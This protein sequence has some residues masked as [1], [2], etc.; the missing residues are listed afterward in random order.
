MVIRFP[1]ISST[2]LPVEI[3]LDVKVEMSES[4]LVIC[5]C[6][7]CPVVI[8]FPLMSSTIAPVEMRLAVLLSVEVLSTPVAAFNAVMSP[9]LSV[10]RPDTVVISVVRV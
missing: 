4:L 10:I 7:V 8:R 3:K 5:V 2:T 1:L 9:S 6:N